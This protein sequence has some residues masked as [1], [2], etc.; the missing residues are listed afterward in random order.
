[1]D[2][3]FVNIVNFVT[4]FIYITMIFVGV[5]Y[6][7][8]SFKKVI[9]SNIINSIV[10]QALG[11]IKKLSIDQYVCYEKYEIWR[12]CVEPNLK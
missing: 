11:Y 5:A 10:I 1:M 12:F 3:N 8:E 7:Y 2:I 4:I 9:E 6:I